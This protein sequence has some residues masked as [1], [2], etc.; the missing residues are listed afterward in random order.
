MGLVAL[1]GL[2]APRADRGSDGTR[3]IS[4]SS[5]SGRAWRAAGP[6]CACAYAFI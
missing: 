5:T 2:A 3:P 4:A 6:N 1:V